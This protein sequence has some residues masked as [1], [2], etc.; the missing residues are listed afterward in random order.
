MKAKTVCSEVLANGKACGNDHLISN[1]KCSVHWTPA[2]TPT[3]WSH[4]D[5][6]LEKFGNQA[7]SKT[8]G[9]MLDPKDAALIVRA[10]N[11]HEA[12]LAFAE[13]VSHNCTLAPEWKREADKAIA[14]AE[15]K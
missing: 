14:K 12:L 6:I 3:P 2:H 1:G 15:A 9:R 10:V 7:I 4:R 8:I 11:A 13:L 5:C